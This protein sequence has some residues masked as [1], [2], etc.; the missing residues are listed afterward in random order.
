MIEKYL[1]SDAVGEHEENA[2]GQSSL[3]GTMCPETVR[4]R[5]DAQAA[6]HVHHEG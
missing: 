2:N 4:S 1:K 6:D 3:I 5:S